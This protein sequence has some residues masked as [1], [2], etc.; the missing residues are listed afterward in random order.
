METDEISNCEMAETEGLVSA[1]S[2]H[3]YEVKTAFWV[4]I[5][6]GLI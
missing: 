4:A 2:N 3:D 5:Y 1:R 6:K